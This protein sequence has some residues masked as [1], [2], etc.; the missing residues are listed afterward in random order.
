MPDAAKDKFDLVVRQGTA[1]LQMKETERF[2][3]ELAV[4]REHDLSA[5][6][7]R[8]CRLEQGLEQLI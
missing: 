7:E 2:Q 1:G 8:G 3:A 6:A 4:R 5:G